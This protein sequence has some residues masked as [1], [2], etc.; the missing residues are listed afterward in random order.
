METNIRQPAAGGLSSSILL[1]ICQMWTIGSERLSCVLVLVGVLLLSRGGRDFLFPGRGTSNG[2]SAVLTFQVVRE[3]AGDD[4]IEYVV[5]PICIAQDSP[6]SMC[7]ARNRAN[8]LVAL[9]NGIES[10]LCESKKSF[11]YSRYTLGRRKVIFESSTS[12]LKHLAV[13]NCAY[14]EYQGLTA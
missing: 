2:C 6:I 7:E 3:V 11:T 4:T 9:H 5:R 13:A 12:E 8:Y 10:M 1:S 14:D